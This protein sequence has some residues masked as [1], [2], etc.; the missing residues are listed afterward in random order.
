MAYD[1]AELPS[2]LMVKLAM[3]RVGYVQH[4]GGWV[5]KTKSYMTGQW[6]AAEYMAY[7]AC[8]QHA[9]CNDAVN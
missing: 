5:T 6:G 3:L 8:M 9:R 7:I 1:G 4:T 2:R